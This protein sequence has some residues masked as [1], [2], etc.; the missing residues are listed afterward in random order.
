SFG[1]ELAEVLKTLPANGYLFPAL[2]NIPCDRR[3]R[4]FA[5]RVRGLGISGVTLHSYRYAWAE[6]AKEAGYPER[7]AMQALGHSSKGVHR[8][9]AKKVQI[10]LPPLEI[11]EKQSSTR[12]PAM[13]PETCRNYPASGA[14]NS[15]STGRP[16][17]LF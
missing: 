4:I 17:E 1:D 2:A 5:R 13:M 11:Y 7:F 8:A 12:L 14:A 6:R 15:S 9:Y 3:A 16:P 10:T